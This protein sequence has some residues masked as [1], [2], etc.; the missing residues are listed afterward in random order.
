MS[1]TKFTPGRVKFAENGDR[2][3][4]ADSGLI[5]ALVI[6]DRPP[7]AQPNA[8][9]IAAAPELHEACRIAL[10]YW[11]SDHPNDTLDGIAAREKIVDALAKAD[12]ER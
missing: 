1:E 10:E 2:C 3:V 11:I 5:V 6:H 7:D 9:L 4:I 12:G 8:H